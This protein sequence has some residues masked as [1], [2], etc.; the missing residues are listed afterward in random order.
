MDIAK[1]KEM[2]Y[3]RKKIACF[4]KEKWH[5]SQKTEMNLLGTWLQLQQ[6]Q[7]NSAVNIIRRKQNNLT[8]KAILQFWQFFLRIFNYQMCFLHANTQKFPWGKQ[9]EWK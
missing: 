7:M 1:G 3:R 4:W 6:A 9:M 2:E 5:N 8:C